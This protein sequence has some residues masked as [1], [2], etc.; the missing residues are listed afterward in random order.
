MYSKELLKG[1]L[2]TIVM[3]LLQEEGRMYGYQI[4]Q[5][6]KV[7]TSGELEL[8]EGAL[9]PTLHKLEKSGLIVSEKE[10]VGGRLR[11][12]YQLSPSGQ[13]QAVNYLE[14]FR[15]FVLSMNR[16]LHLKLD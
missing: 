3:H 12:Y 15:R 5:R 16:I 10:R 9:Y 11:K 4:T 6:V 2:K 1:T 7:L 8:T 14:E 13:T